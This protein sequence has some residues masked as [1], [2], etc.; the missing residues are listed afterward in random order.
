[1]HAAVHGAS[2]ASGVLRPRGRQKKSSIA[3]VQMKS[4]L[5][6]AFAYSQKAFFMLSEKI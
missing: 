1:L 6:T 4:I 5:R 2:D 3:P